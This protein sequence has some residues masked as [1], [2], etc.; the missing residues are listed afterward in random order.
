MAIIYYD[1]TAP[2][3]P[4]GILFAIAA[5]VETFYNLRM[6]DTLPSVVIAG[7]TRIYYICNLITS[8]NI[9]TETLVNNFFFSVAI[10]T[11]S[12]MCK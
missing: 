11:R 2:C 10:F 5:N 9:Y 1:A 7:I 8:V 4:P 12:C 6:K 3:P